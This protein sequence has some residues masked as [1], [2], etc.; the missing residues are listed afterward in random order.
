MTIFNLM[1]L[2]KI[3]AKKRYNSK[4]KKKK[5]KCKG[6]FNRIFY[7]PENIKSQSK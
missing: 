6:G 2:R 4:E 1:T 5:K 3:L 7:F